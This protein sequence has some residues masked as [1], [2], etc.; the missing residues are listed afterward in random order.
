MSTSREKQKKI[1]RKMGIT[2]AAVFVVALLIFGGGT[3]VFT[4]AFT[5]HVRSVDEYQTM[6]LVTESYSSKLEAAGALQSGSTTIVRAEVDGSVVNVAVKEGDAVKKGDIL[7]TLKNDDITANV[8]TT[9]NAYVDAQDEEKDAA[10]SC[11]A[12]KTKLRTAQKALA[13][14]QVA[15]ENAREDAQER[16]EDDPDYTL[17]E[18]PYKVAIDAAQASVESAEETVDALEKN[19]KKAAQNTASAKAAYKKATK[20]ESKLTVKATAAGTIDS[21]AIDKGAAVSSSSDKAAMKIIDTK[22]IVAV[23]EVP[24]GQISNIVK[25]QKATVTCPALPETTLSA[26]VLRVA[27]TP[28]GDKG[29]EAPQGSDAAFSQENASAMSDGSGSGASYNVTLSIGKPDS[30]LKIGMSASAQISIQDY[31]AVYYVPASA[32][33][34][35]NSGVYVEAIVDKSTVKQYGVTQLGTLEDGRLVIQGVSL[36]EGM[37]IRTDLVNK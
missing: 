2:L 30:K 31:G 11:D 27:D 15:L 29:E 25:G 16:Q 13:K 9:L 28:V 20:K 14:A 22:D 23:V 36:T 5:G 8:S 37:T 7:F 33:G 17:D 32:V 24:E 3:Y 10:K 12:A 4:R 1:D 35:N 21:L 34:S 19:Q 6:Q 26:T 18:G